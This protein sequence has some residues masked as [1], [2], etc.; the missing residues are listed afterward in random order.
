MSFSEYFAAQAKHVEQI[1]RLPVFTKLVLPIDDLYR[2]S[3][4]LIPRDS[5]P[6]FGRLL[7]VCHKAFMS[8]ASTIARGQPHDSQG[9]TRRACEAARLARAV[10]YNQENLREWQAYAERFARGVASPA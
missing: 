9:V 3:I 5:K 4:N 7:L 6:Y 2:L 1:K 8:A 10:K